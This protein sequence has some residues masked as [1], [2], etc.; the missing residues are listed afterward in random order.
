MSELQKKNSQLNATVSALEH[1]AQ[2]QLQ[3]LANQ[4]ERALNTA[5]S[6]LGDAK[7]RLDEYKKFIKVKILDIT[8]LYRS[9]KSLIYV[10]MHC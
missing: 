6:R 8:G 5:Q 4:S 1:T 3:V 10:T 9:K 7:T 2:E